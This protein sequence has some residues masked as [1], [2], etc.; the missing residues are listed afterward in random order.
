MELAGR[1]FQRMFEQA[2][3]QFDIAIWPRNFI[4]AKVFDF[5][6]VN[7]LLA[8]LPAITDDQSRFNCGVGLFDL[9]DGKV[10][11]ELLVIDSTR[12]WLEGNLRADMIEEQVELTLFPRSKTARMFALQTPVRISGSFDDLRVAIKPLD[13]VTSYLSFITS[14]L[15][16]PMRRL[17]GKRLPADGSELCATLFDRQKLQ[18]LAEQRKATQ[19]D[20]DDVYY[21]DE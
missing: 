9:A 3:G 7:L 14:P 21:S 2:D 20:I 10:S 8:I 16:A 12:V 1:D 15:H 18:K 4:G 17:L 13:I 6:S 11:E 19:P 5:W